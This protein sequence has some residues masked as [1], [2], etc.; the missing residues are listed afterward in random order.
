MQV[1]RYLRFR[2]PDTLKGQTGWLE[3][4]AKDASTVAWSIVVCESG[5]HIGGTAL[6]R[7]DWRTRHAESGLVLGE[8]SAWRKG[9]AAEAGTLQTGYAFRELNLEKLWGTVM[10][11]ND[12]SRKTLERIGYRQCG[13]MRRHGFVDGRWYDQW[14]GEIL[15][16]EWE[17]SEENRR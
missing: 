1:T 16:E 5:Q 11:D 10:G 12:A 4:T 15:R 2:T 6:E 14:V 13:L 8:K 9:Y 3:A 7:I 17:A